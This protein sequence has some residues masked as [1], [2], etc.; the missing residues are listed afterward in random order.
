M[1]PEGK[2]DESMGILYEALREYGQAGCYPFH[3]PGHKRQLQNRLLGGFPNPYEIDITEIEGFD[4]LHH[5]EGILRASMDRAAE[6]Y[7]ADRTYYLINGSTCGV[8]AA[9]CA[10]VGQEIE[11]RREQEAEN[12]R[13]QGAENRQ[14]Q[15]PDG[16]NRILL[17]RNS[18][19]SAY[20][21]LELSG[22]GADYIYPRILDGMGL[23]G[24][25]MP[26]DTEKIPE[27]TAAV[28]L[29]SPTYDGVVSDVRRIAENCHRQKVPLIVDE[30]HGAHF[31]FG[32]GFPSSALEQGADVVIQSL[33]KTLPAF[34]QTAVL[35]VRGSLIDRDRLE[36]YLQIFQ[37]SSPSYVLM[38]GIERCI[39]YMDGP[40]R[41]KMREFSGR[42]EK[43]SGRLARMKRLRLLDRDRIGQAGVYDLDLSKIVVSAGD[44]GV[45]GREL[46]QLFRERYHL[47]LEMSGADYVTAITTM[48]DSEEGFKR[49]EQAFLE[50][51]EQLEFGTGRS[52]QGEWEPAAYPE[53]VLTLREAVSRPRRRVKLEESAGSVSAEYV[54]LYPPG[55]PILVPGEVLTPEIIGQI[56]RFRSR[57]LPVQGMRDYDVRYIE[58]VRE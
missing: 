19:K 30:A 26:E 51:D 31:P 10:A 8:L 28:F 57:G 41:A 46:M 27:G 58:T 2:G 52:R 32:D 40:G 37:S 4:N 18:H 50:T 53:S 42:L 56:C 9:V 22:A 23:Q 24:G 38:A 39:E 47:E 7:G 55:I 44:T 17:A 35:H 12:R 34:T 45:S 21:V 54:Y 36:H 3:M 33:H 25:V 15:G 20:H 29:T 48:M 1:Y 16:K 11:S 13:D 6:I 49:L 14:G 5:P 43:L